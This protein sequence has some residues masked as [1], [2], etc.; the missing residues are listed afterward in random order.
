MIDAYSC[1]HEPGYA[2]SVEVWHE[3]VLAGGLY[4]V[5]LG[6][7]FF[8]ESMFTSITNASKVALVS[9]CDFLKNLSFDFID[10]Q[11]ASDHLLRLGAKEIP[12]SQFLK[13]LE[14]TLKQPT[15]K[16]KWK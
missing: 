8:G 16:G 1:L 5:S 12:R 7:C 9:L 6:A 4:G 10:C 11:V 14:K 13:E 2:H 15:L 3:G